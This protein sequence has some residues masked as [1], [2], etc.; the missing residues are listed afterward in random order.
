MAGVSLGY[1]RLT[2][3]ADSYAEAFYVHAGAR[4][5]G[6]IPSGPIPDRMIPQ[7]ELLVGPAS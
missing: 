6:E 2:I 5:V 1:E 4:R 7:L 3:D